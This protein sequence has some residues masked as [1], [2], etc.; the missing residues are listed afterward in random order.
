MGQFKVWSPPLKKA[1]PKEGC[2]KWIVSLLA[3]FLLSTTAFAL[4]QSLELKGIATVNVT[5]ADLSDDL[6][7][8]GVEKEAVRT[9]LELALRAA[10]LTLLPEDQGDDAVPT[11][12]LRVSAIK[13]P[14]GRFYA[15]DI[16]LAC[17][18]N[19]SNS[20]IVGPFS[21]IIWTRN[22]LQLLGK[23]DLSRVVE[24]EKKLIDLFVNDYLAANPK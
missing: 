23:V 21:A 19:V 10:G 22:F 8:D 17:L 13:E 1:V 11:I 16:V 6:I 9:T 5:V 15:T 20:R 4:N 7:K 2:M 12:T 14:N 24:G 3:F 18:D